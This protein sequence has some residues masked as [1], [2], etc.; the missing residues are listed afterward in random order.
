MNYGMFSGLNGATF[1]ALMRLSSNVV[2]NAGVGAGFAQGQTS[3][4]GTFRT[5]RD[6]RVESVMR[7]VADVDLLSRSYRPRAVFFVGTSPN[8]HQSMVRQRLLQRLGLSHGARIHRSRSSSVVR[9]TGMEL[10]STA[11]GSVTK[12]QG[13]ERHGFQILKALSPYSKRHPSKMKE[14]VGIVDEIWRH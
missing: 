2:L 7:S 11:F 10:P 13:T 5:W 12:R 14:F 6:V 1:S 4:S 3:A 9:I 8:N